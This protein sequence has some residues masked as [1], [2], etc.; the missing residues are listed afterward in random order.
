M[1]EE[2]IEQLSE[3]D[4]HYISQQIER[5]EN[6]YQNNP[7][8]TQNT[9]YRIA[10]NAELFPVNVIDTGGILTPE[11]TRITWSFIRYF[12]NRNRK[13][14]LRYMCELVKTATLLG[15]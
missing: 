4:I 15:I 8:A 5:L 11:Q 13:S 10:T 6:E 2:K 14:W 7:L 9:L 3:S 12:K 1:F